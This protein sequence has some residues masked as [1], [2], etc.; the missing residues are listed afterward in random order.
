MGLL[1]LEAFLA[2]AGLATGSA[3]GSGSTGAAGAAV[4]MGCSVVIDGLQ[5]LAARARAVSTF[6]S[7]I[8][9]SASR[10]TASNAS[11]MGWTGPWHWAL[12]CGHWTVDFI[13]LVSGVHSALAVA[14]GQKLVVVL[15]W[16]PVH[17]RK[18]GRL[19]RFLLLWGDLILPHLG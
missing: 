8:S 7:S 14:A 9:S 12:A 3:W 1:A 2:R 17:P 19:R 10:T 15:G 11:S 18:A 6:S 5:P 16:R 4:V 13:F